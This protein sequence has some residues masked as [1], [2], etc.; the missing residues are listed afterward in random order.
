[1]FSLARGCRVLGEAELRATSSQMMARNKRNNNS[2]PFCLSG[3]SF[4]EMPE[5]LSGAWRREASSST[6]SKNIFAG[7]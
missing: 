6:L 5:P 2:F 3:S 4:K 7:M 1:M